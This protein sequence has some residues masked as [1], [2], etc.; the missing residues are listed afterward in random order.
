MLSSPWGGPLG[1]V[2]DE[3]GGGLDSLSQYNLRD[4]VPQG[5]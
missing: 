1:G 3:A 5:L 4:V 2:G